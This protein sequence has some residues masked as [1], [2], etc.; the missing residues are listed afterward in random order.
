MRIWADVSL[1]ISVTVTFCSLACCPA[2][3]INLCNRVISAVNSVWSNWSP[4]AVVADQWAT[5]RMGV[6]SVTSASWHRGPIPTR[7]AVPM[8]AR[9][10]FALVVL[11]CV[12]PRDGGA[13]EESP[14]VA[15]AGDAGVSEDAPCQKD[16]DCGFTRVAPGACCPMLCTPRV[17]TRKRAE[18]LEAR[19]PTCSG[20]AGSCPQ[21]LC[22]PPLQNVAPVCDAGRCVTR[23]TPAD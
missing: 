3:E 7:Y 2:S 20:K 22:R 9:A 10:I 19:I 17:V 4:G 21:P 23:T 16:A 12:S 6:R 1:S 8:N 14:T 13:R 15:A 18:E 5:T 11:A